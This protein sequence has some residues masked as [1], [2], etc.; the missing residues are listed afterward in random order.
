LSGVTLPDGKKTHPRWDSLVEEHSILS[1]W[2]HRKSRHC[3]QMRGGWTVSLLVTTTS[4]AE[5]IKYLKNSSTDT[6]CSKKIFQI[7]TARLYISVG[8][9]RM[10]QC[11]WENI[12]FF[13]FSLH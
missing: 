3:C 13:N 11:Y 1:G 4:D 5:N 12:V 8:N 2:Y 6:L 10:V 9:G 7:L